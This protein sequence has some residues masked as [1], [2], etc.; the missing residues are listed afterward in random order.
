MVHRAGHWICYVIDGAG[1]INVRE[2]AV[3]TICNNSDCT[4]AL[5]SEEVGEL[6][7]FMLEKADL[8]AG[9]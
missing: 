8:K 2:A 1:N 9:D 6:A 4:I 7:K 3:S 5:S